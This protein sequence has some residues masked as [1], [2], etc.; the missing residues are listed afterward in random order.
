MPINPTT[1][2]ALIDTQITNETVDFAIT[3]AEVGGRMKDTIDYTTEQVA[4]KQDALVSGTN[5]KT[6]NG[7]SLLGSGNIV[8]NGGTQVQKLQKTTITHAELL[9]LNTTPKVLL[10]TVTDVMYIPSAIVV[11]Y[12][13][14]EGWSNGGGN[15][16]VDIKNDTNSTNLAT[17]ASQLGGTSFN[18]QFRTLT[19][20]APTNIVDSF[21]ER[22]V[23]LSLSNNP[24]TPV[25]SDTTLTVYL[26]YSEIAL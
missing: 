24:T 23:E 10:P 25:S 17:F 6:I 18:E 8:I 3:P 1:L 11:K 20:G 9:A 2:K 5:L 22:R 15:F 16:L 14:N 4:L 26:V 19:S 12:N 7:E 21:F 13:N